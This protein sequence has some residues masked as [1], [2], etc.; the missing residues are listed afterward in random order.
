[1]QCGLKV[2][3]ILVDLTPELV[4]KNSN[5]SAQEYATNLQ[6]VKFFSVGWMR[7][8]FICDNSLSSLL[9]DT[10][11][12]CLFTVPRSILDK[13][14]HCTPW[15][16]LL[17]ETSTRNSRPKIHSRSNGTRLKWYNNKLGSGWFLLCQFLQSQFFFVRLTSSNSE[18]FTIARV[19]HNEN[20]DLND[21]YY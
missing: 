11:W 14:K 6:G 3:Y 19:T 8:T 13:E 1:M 10:Q 16:L 21:F 15:W 9:R 12:L 2:T 20:L 4:S 17:L 7:G 18:T 5:Y